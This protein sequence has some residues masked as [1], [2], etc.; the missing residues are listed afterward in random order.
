MGC[1]WVVLLHTVAF[2][3]KQSV[4]LPPT[5]ETDDHNNIGYKQAGE[6]VGNRVRNVP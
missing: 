2:C 1:E 6:Y 4:V 5:I 3:V